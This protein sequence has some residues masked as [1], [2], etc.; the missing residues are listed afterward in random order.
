MRTGAPSEFI[1][2]TISRE[3]QP[4]YRVVLK[5]SDREIGLRRGRELREDLHRKWDWMEPFFDTWYGLPRAK[6]DATADRLDANA[7]KYIPWMAEQMD[8]M[9]EG[10]GLS[11]RD[12][13][14]TN[15]YGLIWSTAGNWCTT[16]AVRQ[17]EEGP[18]LGQN[19][20]IGY[21]DFY[22]M[23]EQ[24]PE[25]AHA[26]MGDRKLGL[27]WTPT[28]MNA[29]GLAVGSSNLGAPGQAHRPWSLD[30]LPF[31]FLPSLIL[32]ECASVAEA[33]AFLRALPPTIPSGGGY[34]MNLVDSSGAMAVVDK[35]GERTVVRQCEPDL[36]FT[37]NC[38]LD[39]E[40]EQWRLG[41]PGGNPDGQ[42]RVDRIRKEWAAL[43][44]QRPTRE[45][46]MNLMRSH[47][48]DGHICR[49]NDRG[50]SRIGFILSPAK[51]TMDISNG[52]PDRTP[53]ERM[54]FTAI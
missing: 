38:T 32:R 17:T 35:T 13:L 47:T 24:H 23:E 9:A 30:G 21:G 39:E 46:L 8:G 40:F 2:T 54:T 44:G 29:K 11:L 50:Y 12:L 16:V 25:H 33:T 28:G 15:Y 37:S 4:I 41:A 10:S 27:C 45:W 1:P 18:L 51:L 26:V 5:G 52:P 20:D 6:W 14:L 22:Y 31:H 3:G 7:R 53:Y 36:N 34:Q 43:K 49:T 42:E 48:G 19:L